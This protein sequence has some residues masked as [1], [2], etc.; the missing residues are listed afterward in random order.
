MRE[1]LLCRPAEEQDLPQ[2]QALWSQ[3][4]DDTPAF[5]QWYFRRYYQAQHTLGIFDGATLLASAQMI[6]YTISLRGSCVPAAYIVGVDTAPEAR[7]QGCARTLLQ[8]CLRMQRLRGQSISL[9]MPFEGQFYYRY[10]WPFCYFHQQMMLEPQ[11]LRCAA[12]PWGAIRQVDIFEAIPKLERIYQRFVQG[13]HGTVCRDSRQWQLLLEDAAMEHTLCFL[14]EQEGVA[15]GYCLWTPLKGK[16]FIREMAWCCAEAKAGLLYFLEQNVPA[17]QKLWLELPDDDDLVFQLAAAKKSVVRYP[18][19]MARIVDVVQCLEAIHYPLQQA[20][21][22]LAVTDTFAPWNQ[23]V[24]RLQ[25]REGRGHVQ[26]QPPETEAAVEIT[27]EGLSQLV[28]GVRSV[29]QLIRQ[30]MLHVC[31][32]ALQE[33]LKQLWP[34]QNTYINE[35]Y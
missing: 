28:L 23:G 19:L 30:N 15:Q 7:N 26:P 3:C 14:L 31:D 22:D 16:I 12:A 10:G 21:V 6:P 17:G 1:G 34:V 35:Y 9:L 11:E 32:T 13:Y 20:Q 8:E 29:A 18:F 25:V 2:I 4:F 24:F 5:V 27:I 33:L